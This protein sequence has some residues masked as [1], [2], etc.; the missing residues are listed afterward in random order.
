VSLPL[1]IP[2]SAGQGFL[3]GMLDVAEQGVEGAS[4]ACI[5]LSPGVKPKGGPHQ[6]YRKLSPAFVEKGVPVLRLDFSGIG[7]SHGST[8]SNVLLDVYAE[9]QAGC[10]VPDVVAAMNFLAE[11]Y[12]I[13]RFLVGGLCGAAITGL[14]AAEVD[15]RVAGL[16]SIGMPVVLVKGKA[17][18]LATQ[19]DASLA[20]NLQVLRRKALRPAHWWRLLTLKSDYRLLWSV[21]QRSAAILRS[22]LR[23]AADELV[24]G[25]PD[26][27]D[28]RCFSIASSY[29]RCLRWRSRS[30][31]AVAVRRR[32]SLLFEYQEYFAGTYA[33]RLGLNAGRIHVRV[34][35]QANHVLGQPE[36]VEDAK[37]QIAD[38]LAGDIVAV[39]SPSATRPGISWRGMRSGV[40]A[41]ARSTGKD[42]LEP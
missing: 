27:A 41:I 36:W 28:V 38:W 8:T 37:S 1:A 29:M 7:D 32:G 2:R 14:L 3:Y 15:E 5:L 21:L 22:S 40:G 31:V 9:V 24:G 35:P 17:A 26:K 18:A 23:A 34:V 10:Y 16:F 25:D 30:L 42:D 4:V 39:Q 33:K 11:H 6:L 13:Q 12:G 19:T 20:A